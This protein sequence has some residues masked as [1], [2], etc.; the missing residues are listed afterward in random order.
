MKAIYAQVDDEGRD[1]VLLDAIVD[2]KRDSD[3]ALDES[4]GFEVKSNGNRIPKRT[5]MGWKLKARWKDGGENWIPLKDLKDSNPLE[6]VTY[7]QNTGLVDEPAFAWWVPHFI[8]RRDRIVSKLGTSKYW[9]TTE[10]M[11]ITVPRTIE[12]AYALDKEDGTT[13]WQEAIAKEMKHVLPAFKDG[14]CT[15]DQIKNHKAL[16]G[17][18]KI[19]CHLIFDVKMDFTRKARFVAGGHVTDPPD[20]IT[21]SS[22]VSRETVRISFLLAALN[23]LDVCAADIGNAY[24]NADCA[25]KIYTVAGTE[26]G[27][28]LQGKVLIRYCSP[29]GF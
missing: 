14:N 13:L 25:E 17:Y 7:A 1:Y 16:I 22:V 8:A 28:Q 27:P 23:D 9:R 3:V 21:Y 11:G 10:K 12:Q 15:V 24:L 6:V 18:Q 26:F 5:T 20:C 19:R 4:N 29:P 2:H